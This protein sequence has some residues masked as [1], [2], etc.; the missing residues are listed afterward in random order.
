MRL[1]SAC[2]SL[3][4]I[5]A[6]CAF[7]PARD[8]AVAFPGRGRNSTFTIQ[9]DPAELQKRDGAKY[10]FMHHVRPPLDL[11][12]SFSDHGEVDCRQ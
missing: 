5:S 10:V 11:R 7:T 12:R 6:A 9:E 2:L 1:F 3:T 8:D 4:L